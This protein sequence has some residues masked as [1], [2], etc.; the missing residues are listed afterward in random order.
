MSQNHGKSNHSPRPHR[1]PIVTSDGRPPRWKNG[2]LLNAAQGGNRDRGDNRNRGDNHSRGD[3][4]NRGD[5][6]KH[7]GSHSYIGGKSFTPPKA[8]AEPVVLGVTVFD[9]SFEPTVDRGTNGKGSG[10][11]ATRRINNRPVFLDSKSTVPAQGQSCKVTLKDNPRHTVY[12]A[13]VQ[14]EKAT[15]VGPVVEKT[16]TAKFTPTVEKTDTAPGAVLIAKRG[17]TFVWVGPHRATCEPRRK[18]MNTGGVPFA[19]F[20][21]AGAKDL[22]KTRGP[23]Y[24]ENFEPEDEES[25]FDNEVN[26]YSHIVPAFVPFAARKSDRLNW[27][28]VCMPTSRRLQIVQ[29]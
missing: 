25:A 12:F 2:V 15:N 24:N 26:T 19:R 5:S 23:E 27:A 28:S 14:V 17:D 22:F 18:S 1:G 13:F 20:R 10:W 11:I 16:A 29:F 6:H 7:G 9:L 4:H 3:N 8:K 21:H